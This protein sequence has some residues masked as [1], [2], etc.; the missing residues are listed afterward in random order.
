MTNIEQLELR[1]S[2][3][4]HF[5]LPFLLLMKFLWLSK[6]CTN[7]CSVDFEK[8]N[9]RL[10]LIA[11][12][13]NDNVSLLPL[14]ASF[15]LLSPLFCSLSRPFDDVSCFSVLLFFFFSLS[16]LSGAT[17]V[18]VSFFP[19][20]SPSLSLDLFSDGIYF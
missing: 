18:S 12:G 14:L 16:Q 8:E 2:C 17:S 5:L 4:S 11:A 20:P 7:L 19:L 1:K 9:A 3:L 6:I 10:L 15:R 13:I